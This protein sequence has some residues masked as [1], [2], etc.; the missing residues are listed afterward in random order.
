[1]RPHD[2]LADAAGRNP[3]VALALGL[4]AVSSALDALARA[5]L[6]ASAAADEADEPPLAS[7]DPFVLAALGLIALRHTV[8][9]WLD[10]AAAGSLATAPRAP[11]GITHDPGDLAR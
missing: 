1:M 6:A 5:D 10:V 7:D 3:L 9:A 11:H 8:G 4:V 2:R